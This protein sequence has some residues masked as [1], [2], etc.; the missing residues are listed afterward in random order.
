MRSISAGLFETII[1]A[2]I[3]T[4]A[5]IPPDDIKAL[6]SLCAQNGISR[7]FLMNKSILFFDD[8]KEI[9]SYLRQ[10]D[11]ASGITSITV[12]D[13][14]IVPFLQKVIP[15]VKIQSSVFLHIDSAPK[16]REAIKMGIT[17]FCLDVTTNRNG[18][19][20][21]RIKL[22]RKTFPQIKIKLLANHGC[23]L[24]C[25]Y[26]AK[27]EDWPVLVSQRK[28]VPKE[29]KRLLVDFIN[30]KK[31]LYRTSDLTDEI[32]RPFIRPEDIT[33][34]EKKGW[35]DYIKLAYRLDETPVLK[36][37]MEAYFNRKYNG[38]IC[39]LAPPNRG[40]LPGELL[41]SK[42]PKGFIE[43]LTS[44]GLDCEDCPYCTQVLSLVLSRRKQKE[45]D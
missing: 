12:A 33:F 18:A 30:E 4:C 26:L 1:Q 34:Y 7:N 41:N 20:L 17:E 16:I 32:R 38:D 29:E 24:H 28:R 43:K 37:R 35:T 13:R 8:L 44:C 22:L 6:I 10:L 11:A 36:R 31:C 39:D 21:E 3:K 42:F 23:Y 25:F 2:P 5:G 40:R 45:K 9:F 14:A 27:H 15:D 19:E